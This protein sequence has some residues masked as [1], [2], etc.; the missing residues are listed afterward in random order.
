MCNENPD[1][2]ALPEGLFPPPPPPPRVHERPLL[3]ALSA[4]SGAGK[5]TLCNRLIEEHPGV[6][7]S[8]SCTTRAPRGEEQDGQAYY[9]LTKGEFKQRVR[10]GEFLEHAK[11]H[12]HAY[13]TLKQSVEFAMEEGLHIIMDIDVQGVAQLR[14]SIAKMDPKSLMCQG[15]VD[16]FIQPPS[17][18]ELARRLQLRG[19]DSP[20]VIRKRLK[21]AKAEIDCA[22]EYQ[23]VIINDQLE[24]AYDQLVAL[25]VARV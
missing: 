3:I 1:A 22:A 8:I 13:G 17:I 24:A 5:S 21:R 7:Y 16:I 11:V 2:S 12:G 25:T 20:A 19:T 4:P 10:R 6:A 15:F 18:E 9:F 14:A 23:H